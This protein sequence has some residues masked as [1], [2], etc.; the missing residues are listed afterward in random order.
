[1]TI[2]HVLACYAGVAPV[3]LWAALPLILGKV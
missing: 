3:A 2:W 1:M